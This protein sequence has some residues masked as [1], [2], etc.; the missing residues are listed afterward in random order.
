MIEAFI[1]LI[2]V[3]LVVGVLYWAF[4]QII[5]IFPLPDPFGRAVTVLVK[6][7]AVLIVLA[8]FSQVFGLY[9]AGLPILRPWRR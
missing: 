6:V 9:D 1:S 4:T 7:L 2:V 5:S 8:A 3:L